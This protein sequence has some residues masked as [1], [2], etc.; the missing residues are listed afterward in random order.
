VRSSDVD[1]SSL[2]VNLLLLMSVGPIIGSDRNMKEADPLLNLLANSE[3]EGSGGVQHHSAVVL[4]PGKISC[5]GGRPGW[6]RKL[7]PPPG[8]DLRTVQPE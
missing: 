5:P 2:A 3:L 4:P 1:L 7:S 8:F 6:A